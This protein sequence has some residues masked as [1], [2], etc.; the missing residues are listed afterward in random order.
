MSTPST[1]PLLQHYMPFVARDK[2]RESELGSC[3]FAREAWVGLKNDSKLRA[4]GPTPALC[5]WFSWRDAHEHWVSVC[6]MRLLICLIWGM[7]SGLLTAASI[8]E[9]FPLCKLPEDPDAGGKKTMAEE[10]A[11][12]ARV[13]SKGNTFPVYLH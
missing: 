6:H 13:R 12:Q 9:G 5:R 4:R 3:E 8:R 1:C 7:G 2:G 10:Q 11:T